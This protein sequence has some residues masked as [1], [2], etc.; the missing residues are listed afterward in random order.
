M[1][2]RILRAEAVTRIVRGPAVTRVVTGLRGLRGAPGPSG[3][4]VALEGYVHTQASPLATWTVNHN[5]GRKPLVAVL[6]VGG[7]EVIAEVLHASNNQV[8]ISFAS[9]AV[10]SARCL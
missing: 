3:D 6:S 9:P 5:L 4:V 2:D 8:L 7:Q 10:G 1:P